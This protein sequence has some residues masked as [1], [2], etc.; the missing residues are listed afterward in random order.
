MQKKRICAG[1]LALAL[2]ASLAMPAQAAGKVTDSVPPMPNVTKHMSDGWNATWYRMETG[3]QL[4]DV[5]YS[6]DP[7]PAKGDSEYSKGIAADAYQI[8]EMPDAFKGADFFITRPNNN[9]KLVFDAEQAVT[10]YAA[11]DTSYA[12]NPSCLNG[13]NTTN[14]TMKI[15][16]GTNYRVVSKNF[17]AGTINLGIGNTTNNNKNIFY[18]ILPQNGQTVYN[19]T[20]TNNALVAEGTKPAKNAA[21]QAYQY[22]LNDVFNTHSGTGVPSGYAG[23][24][25]ALVAV[26]GQNDTANQKTVAAGENM[27]LNMNY[28]ANGTSYEGSPVDGDDQTYWQG[29]R[30]YSTSPTL[31]TPNVL[32]IDLGGQAKI[33]SVVLKARKKDSWADRTQNIKIESSTDGVNYQALANA[34]DY[35]FTMTKN[36]VLDPIT[37]SETTARFVRITIYTNDQQDAA[38]IAECEIYGPAQTYELE[39]YGADFV[40]KAMQITKADR[41]VYETAELTKTFDQNISGKVIYE[42]KV[43]SSETNQYMEIPV[44]TDA[45]GNEAVKVYFDEDGHIKAAS[46]NGVVDVAPYTANTWY[47][48]KILVDTDAD[49]YEVW[50]DHIR[51]AQN[52]SFVNKVDNIKTMRFAVGMEAKGILN[53]DNLR[54]YDNPE[55]YT[56]Y[57]EFNEAATG[58]TYTTGWSYTNSGNAKIANV[59]FA[60]D[61]SIYLNGTGN[62]ATRTFDPITGDVTVEVKVKP[63][64]E[65]WVTMPMITDNS[66]KV[67]AK[68]AFYQNSFFIANGDNWVYVCDQEIPNNYYL[69][70]TWFIVKLV[71]NTYT[72]RYDFYVDGALRYSG[73]SF[74]EDVDSISKVV[75]K[76]EENS[77]MY[78]DNVTVYDSASL[79]RGLYPEENVFNVRDYGAKGDG[80]TDDTA[81]VDAAVL[82]AAGTGG[83]VLFENGTFYVGQIIPLS[84][85]SI[86]VD[87]SAT[88]LFKYD[89]NEYKHIVAS[90]GY[91]GNHQLGA[92]L[93]LT[94]DGT[95]NVR[96]EGGGTIDA[97]GLYAFNQ[98]DPSN[99]RPCTMYLTLSHDITVQNLNLYNAQHW[100]VVPYESENLTFRNIAITNHIAPNRDG[101]DPTNCSNMTVE[102][103]N[104]IAG[105]DAFCPKSG[106][107]V[108]SY[109]VDVRNCLLTSYCNGIKF[110]TDAQGPFKN[111]NFEDIYVKSVGMAAITLQAVDGSEMQNISFKRIDIIDTVASVNLALGHRMRTG[112]GE[113]K[114]LGF[115]R[116]IYF[117]ELS[118][119]N[120]MRGTYNHKDNI[121]RPEI[122]IYGLNPANNSLNDGKDHTVSNVYFKN[123]NM[124]TIGGYTTTPSYD[125]DG[126]GGGYP[127]YDGLGQSVGYGATIRWA[128]NV[129]FDNSCTFTTEQ[130]DS[131]VKLAYHPADYS[132]NA[133]H[134]PLFG[135]YAIGVP[136]KIVE[137]GTPKDSIGLPT[138]VTV[139]REDNKIIEVGVQSWEGTYDPAKEG[140]Y[141]LTAKLA[142]SS[143]LTNEDQLSIST[144]VYVHNDGTFGDVNMDGKVDQLDMATI[145]EWILSENATYEEVKRGDFS[146]N[147]KLDVSDIMKLKVI[148]KDL[149]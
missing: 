139:L 72:N 132:A 2:S 12:S 148:I 20:Q 108:P 124:E 138:T 80:V 102:N 93:F 83:T 86:F 125:N 133:Y 101:I 38:Q 49:T 77:Q 14:Y 103:C 75:F 5:M 81:A 3:L 1:I 112:T 96:I 147:G 39:P 130:A 23:E 149:A 84:D 64:T 22:Y 9:Q 68:V 57:D 31:T 111:Y 146:G 85:M 134:E 29:P 61:K 74:V 94:E 51:K 105:D 97:D 17:N 76:N 7:D 107:M 143:D 35:L 36:N 44:M 127:E 92:G 42:G 27:A 113:T 82:A 65:E 58:S 32:T 140:A 4:G 69:A 109:N 129:V 114:H 90:N 141:T 73:A 53:V 24:N 43:R 128:N 16:D 40:D 99:Q 62:T 33:S 70:E 115:I 79:A 46:A 100:T 60:T 78:I 117:D 11:V 126:F 28:T 66:G 110:G 55:I 18:M 19:A 30:G 121:N 136:D 54:L 47:T 91:N 25:A 50:V 48:M 88:L 59:P 26:N 145:K 41:F 137:M 63:M 116:D 56:V 34:K 87:A 122:L 71:M 15:K 104:I 21:D 45:N 135:F 89:R 131:R 10:I 142:S 37:F 13:W 6:Y 95:Q 118:F 98:N 8:T 144:T 120:A 52:I 119:Q 123:V 67:A 106:N